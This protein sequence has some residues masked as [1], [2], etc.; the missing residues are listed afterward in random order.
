MIL[1]KAPMTPSIEAFFHLP[2]HQSPTSLSIDVNFHPP[3]TYT[4]YILAH[5]PFSARSSK[6][7]TLADSGGNDGSTSS[8]LNQLAY[9][10]WGRAVFAGLLG[11]EGSTVSPRPTNRLPHALLHLLHLLHLLGFGPS[12]KEMNWICSEW[13]CDAMMRPTGRAALL[14][15]AP[16]LLFVRPEHE[17]TC[18]FFMIVL[19]VIS[20]C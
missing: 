14:Y 9:L 7:Q 19:I 5:L 8:E 4:Q 10:Q 15:T 1:C 13:V 2:H 12:L 18:S 3:P 11:S 6:H 17:Q 16:V 20:L